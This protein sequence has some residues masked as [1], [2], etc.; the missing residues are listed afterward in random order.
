[1]TAVIAVG[2]L[3]LG[4]NRRIIGGSLVMVV[5]TIVIGNNAVVI[6]ILVTVLSVLYEM[7]FKRFDQSITVE[8]AQHYFVDLQLLSHCNA[9]STTSTT[10]AG[11]YFAAEATE[12][13]WV[14]CRHGGRIRLVMVM[15]V[16]VVVVA[17]EWRTLKL[18]GGIMAITIT[19][20]IATLCGR[21]ACGSRHLTTTRWWRLAHLLYLHRCYAQSA[22][23]VRVELLYIGHH[24][25]VD[26][27]RNGQ[28]DHAAHRHWIAFF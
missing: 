1:M 15:T 20:T 14:Q 18:V 16:V 6:I 5:E 3:D 25:L 22:I 9:W 2:V 28:R 7:F 26:G 4:H 17:R 11:H 21:R 27:R 24:R 8:V 10:T 13:G 19:S 23:A 12:H